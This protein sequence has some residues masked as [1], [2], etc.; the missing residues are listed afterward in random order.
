MVLL[1]LL[2]LAVAAIAGLSWWQHRRNGHER[3]RQVVRSADAA[4]LGTSPTAIG[5]AGLTQPAM[6]A[7]PP[8]AIGLAGLTQ[9]PPIPAPAWP[10]AAVPVSSGTVT[11]TAQLVVER[12]EEG[13]E[14]N[15]AA[16][17][18]CEP[19]LDLN[20]VCGQ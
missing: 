14:W 3:P 19:I 13:R 5:L 7:L 9:P 8:V 10:I 12:D 11:F 4:K 15:M 2:V 20:R 18:T 6:P 1:L 17:R 16:T